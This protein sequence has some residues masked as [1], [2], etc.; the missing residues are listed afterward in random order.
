MDSWHKNLGTSFSVFEV[1][2]TNSR[3]SGSVPKFKLRFGYGLMGPSAIELIQPLGGETI[4]SQ[5]LLERGPG[6]HHLG[7][8]VAN[9]AASRSQLASEGYSLLMEGSID[10]LGAMAYYRLRG[11]HC[12]IEPLQLSIELSLFLTKRATAY[13]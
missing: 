9:L 3:F 10:E 5:Y 8:L 4:Y 11:G 13:P 7:F 6:L 1:D 2:E 12:V